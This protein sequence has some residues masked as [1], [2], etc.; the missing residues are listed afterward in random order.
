MFDTWRK[1]LGRAAN[2]D[3]AE[4]TF[5][6]VPEETETAPSAAPITAPEETETR[7]AS[8]GSNIEFKIVTP[9]AMDEVFTI[10]NHLI[11]GC[12]V[13]INMEKMERAMVT[14]MLDFLSGVTYTTGGEVKYV[15][16]GT[17]IVT[18]GSA[19]SKK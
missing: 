19:G 11:D 13:V 16:P 15:S 3:D 2:E 10:A 7:D 6:S 14:R 9:E 12:T 17:Y 18:P 5:K 8:D 1:K 4:I